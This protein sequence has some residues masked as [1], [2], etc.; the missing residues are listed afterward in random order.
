MYLKLVNISAVVCLSSFYPPNCTILWEDVSLTEE[1]EEEEY[2]LCL[3]WPRSHG[4]MK[5]VY[6]CDTC[7]R[8]KGLVSQLADV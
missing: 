6:S 5:G 2:C 4:G 8:I 1:G 3:L 7:M